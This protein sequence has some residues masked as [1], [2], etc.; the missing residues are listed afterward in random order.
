MSRMV[1]SKFKRVEPVL[2]G[3]TKHKRLHFTGVDKSLLV[4]KPTNPSAK[5]KRRR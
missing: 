1:A 3:E 2:Y 5:T 4:L